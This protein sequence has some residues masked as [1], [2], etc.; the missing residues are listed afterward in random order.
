MEKIDNNM[1]HLGRE[2]ELDDSKKYSS[3]KGNDDSNYLLMSP[4]I[5]HDF[6]IEHR[7]KF[8]NKKLIDSSKNAQRSKCKSPP[9]SNLEQLEKYNNDK[10]FDLNQKFSI[11]A[12]NN[13]KSQ[14]TQKEI[15]D[16][17]L[18][19]LRIENQFCDKIQNESQNLTRNV[20]ETVPIRKRFKD[21]SN[22]NQTNLIENLNQGVPLSEF[23]KSPK[24][25][26]D[27]DDKNAYIKKTE[28]EEEEKHGK[29]KK[30]NE[31]DDLFNSQ[32][33]DQT[34]REIGNEEAKSRAKNIELSLIGKDH[35]SNL[36]DIPSI[37]QIKEEKV[38]IPKEEKKMNNKKSIAIPRNL[39]LSFQTLPLVSIFWFQLFRN[40]P[41]L[42]RNE[43]PL[44][45]L[46]Y[47]IP[48]IQDIQEDQDKQNYLIL[49]KKN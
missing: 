14:P 24:D 6:S 27:E 11:Q 40:Y 38:I 47:S 45:E 49:E 8:S 48:I 18:Q 36:K 16:N 43:V 5:E 7:K 30:F 13:H 12:K 29:I 35:L 4:Q 25:E 44:N 22:Y 26:I 46:N 41:I 31:N 28:N 34:N 42:E 39:I 10:Q 9:F 37:T 3:Y 1:H 19:A 32:R 33:L 21:N 15:N 23:N 20:K 17:S 2:N